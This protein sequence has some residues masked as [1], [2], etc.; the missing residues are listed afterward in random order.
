[1]YGHSVAFDNTPSSAP[2]GNEIGRSPIRQRQRRFPKA[3][4]FVPPETPASLAD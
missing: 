1:M 2:P 3:I 4:G